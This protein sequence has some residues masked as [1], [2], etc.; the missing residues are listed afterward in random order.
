[1]L[2]LVL[3]MVTALTHVVSGQSLW[4]RVRPAVWPVALMSSLLGLLLG[5]MLG[6]VDFALLDGRLGTVDVFQTRQMALLTAVYL[7][8][9]CILVATGDER[10]NLVAVRLLFAAGVL[11]AAFAIVMW[12]SGA[13]YQF[14][15]QD[16]AHGGRARGSFVY[17]NSLACYLVLML[18]LGVALVM[19]DMIRQPAPRRDHLGPGWRRATMSV[20]RFLLSSRMRIRLLM[21]VMVIALVLTRSRM[22]N[23]AF[24]V[25]ALSASALV[26]WRWRRWRRPALWLMGSLLVFDVVVLGQWVGLDHVVA[27]LQGTAITREAGGPQESVE[28]RLEPSR[29]S[30][31]MIAE[32]PWF[33]YGGGTYYL[34]F[35]PWKTPSMW[36]YFD[37][38]HNDYIEWAADTGLVGLALLSGLVL[39]SLSRAMRM[40]GRGQSSLARGLGLAVLMMG[41]ALALHSLVD[42]NLQIPAIALNV[43]VIL[44]LAWSVP[45]RGVAD[46]SERFSESRGF[47][48]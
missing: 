37:H 44:G 31:P 39:A 36:L 20:G 7:A 9:F 42:F 24:F 40:M 46:S 21:I 19:R 15:H 22:G 27:R 48:S 1:M 23:V 25:A 28:A 29:A 41:V 45:L 2:V 16:I 26:A 35:A 17:F 47:S 13:H 10:R 34:S 14:M 8:A 6:G 3:A 5:Q 11:Q 4:R 30:L 38:A 12:A 33:G 18:C 32:R 43:V